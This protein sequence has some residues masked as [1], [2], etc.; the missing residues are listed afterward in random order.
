MAL[1]HFVQVTNLL[2]CDALKRWLGPD[3]PVGTEGVRA[4]GAS[5]VHISLPAM[6]GK[7]ERAGKLR[8][9][10]AQNSHCITKGPGG[11]ASLGLEFHQL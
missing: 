8:A 5:R 3:Q 4:T 6:G 2:T 1:S 10:E 9:R 7:A 11:M